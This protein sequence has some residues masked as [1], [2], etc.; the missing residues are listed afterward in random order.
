MRGKENVLFVLQKEKVLYIKKVRS[1]RENHSQRAR[2]M[3]SAAAAFIF[4]GRRK[5]TRTIFTPAES[6]P[7][8]LSEPS[9]HPSKSA[10]FVGFDMAA[11]MASCFS[12]FFIF[13]FSCFSKMGQPMNDAQQSRV[14]EVSTRFLGVKR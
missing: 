11:I 9:L 5:P 8:T 4:G 6:R 7:R 14:F 3:I 13:A 10:S 1:G 2:K 12:P